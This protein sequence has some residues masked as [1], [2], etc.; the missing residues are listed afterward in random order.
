GGAGRDGAGLAGAAAALRRAG[1]AV[2]ERGRDHE[3][4]DAAHLHADHALV[5]ARDDLAGPD[6]EA[7]EGLAAVAAGVELGAVVE[8]AGVVDADQVVLL[9]HLAGAGGDVD[10][11]EPVGKLDRRL[12]GA[13]VE[14]VGARHRGGGG[15]GD[16]RHRP[17]GW[18]GI[19][20]A[21]GGGR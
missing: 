11:L 5:P 15:G 17:V 14:V 19:G 18:V 7:V 4:P 1:V 21:A 6:L 12:A 9:H 13:G 10:V 16:D 3:A 2:T 8:P 20:I